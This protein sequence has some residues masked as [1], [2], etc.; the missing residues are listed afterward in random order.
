MEIESYNEN[1][2]W[3]AENLNG[4]ITRIQDTLKQEGV[5]CTKTGVSSLFNVTLKIRKNR[6]PRNMDINIIHRDGQKGLN[7]LIQEFKE[8]VADEYKNPGKAWKEYPERWKSFLNSGGRM[9]YSYHERINR[10]GQIYGVI[11]TLINHPETRQAYLSIY[12]SDIDA[13]RIEEGGWMI[14]CILGYQFTQVKQELNMTVMARSIDVNNCLM[15]DIWLADSLLVHIVEKINH[16]VKYDSDRKVS[17]GSI[18]FM[19]NNLHLYPDI[20]LKKEELK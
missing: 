10:R 2:G 15:N 9:D 7:F 1:Q 4:L 17:A 14:P 18:T 5:M 12:H 6:S 3:R 19:I 13:R 16:R 20:V 8:W 11:Q